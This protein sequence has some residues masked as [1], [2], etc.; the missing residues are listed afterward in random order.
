MWGLAIISGENLQLITGYNIQSDHF[1][2]RMG[3]YWSA[4]TIA[5]IAARMLEWFDSRFVSGTDQ[6]ASKR[7]VLIISN[8]MKTFSNVL[9]ILLLLGIGATQYSVALTTWNRHRVEHR[10]VSL[11][12][13][14]HNN[15]ER[16]SVVGSPYHFLN[17]N[18]PTNSH[19][20]I[21]NPVSILSLASTDELYE[22]LCVIF[23]LA[24]RTP[25]DLENYLIADNTEK[26]RSDSLNSVG[27]WQIDSLLLQDA[28]EPW[29]TTH[30]KYLHNKPSYSYP[31]GEIESLLKRFQ[32]INAHLPHF[33]EKYKLDYLILRNADSIASSVQHRFRAVAE[34]DDYI[35]YV[36]PAKSIY[37]E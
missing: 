10:L 15:T 32:Y 2:G 3:I 24:S 11:F 1:W 19:V 13:W 17:L 34:L 8:A 33:L 9:I 29:Y 23:A 31:L 6:V 16:E 18:L 5:I 37:P 20:Y 25:K 14:L 30:A 21:Y 12:N 35:V 7:G 26:S 27:G 22:R 36:K 28:M 4:I